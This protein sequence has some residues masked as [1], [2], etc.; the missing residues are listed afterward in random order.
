M[1]IIQSYIVC[2]YGLIS[3]AVFVKGLIESTKYKRSFNATPFLFFLGIFVWGDAVVFGLFWFLASL[4]TFFL[5]DWLL[6]LLI[7]SVF[8]TVRGLG[9][10]VYWFNQQFSTI[11]RNPPEKL[12]GFKL[13][14]NSSIWFIYQIVWQCITIVSIIA[15]I[16]FAGLW[17]K[18]VM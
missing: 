5:K 7:I 8:W 18:T 2:A 16:F 17:L 15:S 1:N 3:L 9:E 14:K 13:F 10:P 4:L 11:N 6:F 12:L